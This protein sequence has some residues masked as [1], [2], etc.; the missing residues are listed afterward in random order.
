MSTPTKIV[1]GTL[2]I[3]LVISSGILAGLVLA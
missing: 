1:L 2:V 3:A